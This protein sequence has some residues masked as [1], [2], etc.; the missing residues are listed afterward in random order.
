MNC[1]DLVYKPSSLHKP[2]APAIQQGSKV[3]KELSLCLRWLNETLK[4]H[5]GS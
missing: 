4:C 1:S 3:K 5:K 2:V